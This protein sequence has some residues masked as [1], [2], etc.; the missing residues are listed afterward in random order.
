MYTNKNKI[1]DISIHKRNLDTYIGQPD[2]KLEI[3]NFIN[4]DLIMFNYI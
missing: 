2:I 3:I 4:V 1:I